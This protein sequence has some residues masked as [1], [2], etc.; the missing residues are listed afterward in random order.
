[1]RSKFCDE[2]MQFKLPQELVDAVA[3]VSRKRMMSRSAYCRQALVEKL[4]RDGICIL[5]P[6]T[7]AA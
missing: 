7:V 2:Q 4:E 5:T 1:M 6:K 3:E